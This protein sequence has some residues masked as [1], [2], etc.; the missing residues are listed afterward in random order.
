MTSVLIPVDESTKASFTTIENFV[1]ANVSSD[2]YKP[3]WLKDFMYCNV[4]HWCNY[5]QEN[6]DG[7]QCVVTPEPNYKNFGRGTYSML[8]QA[9]HVYVGP[10][11]NGETYSLSLHVLQIK[12]KPYN[13]FID[14]IEN[15]DFNC[16]DEVVQPQVSSL[17]VIGVVQPQVS[18]LPAAQVTPS[19]LQQS[20]QYLKPTPKKRGG[21]ANKKALDE[22]DGHKMIPKDLS[23]K[24]GVQ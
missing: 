17:P 22:I 11:K 5:I 14:F 15:F 7:S 13:N 3:L 6:S 24:I 18:S 9:S 4:S 2:K 12:Y 1:Q 21:R 20:E 10:H 16:G 8:I 19:L 23:A